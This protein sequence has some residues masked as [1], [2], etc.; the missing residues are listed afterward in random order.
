MDGVGGSCPSPSSPS[1]TSQSSQ[2]TTQT[3]EE[4]WRYNTYIEDNDGFAIRINHLPEDEVSDESGAE[5]VAKNKSTP[6]QTASAAHRSD[7]TRMTKELVMAMKIGE[8]SHTSHATRIAMPHHDKKGVF[9]LTFDGYHSSKAKNGGYGAILRCGNGTPVAAV[10]GGSKYKISPFFHTLEGLQKGLDLVIVRGIKSVYC[11]CN[12]QRVCEILRDCFIFNNE[13]G[14][15]RHPHNLFDFVCPHCLQCK[16]T[17]E[18]P[19]NLVIHTLKD[20]VR[21][22]QQFYRQ[23]QGLVGA[24][25]KEWNKPA[26]YLAKL[27]RGPGEERKLAPEE[28][29]D[30]LLALVNQHGGRNPFIYK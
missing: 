9:L 23:R 21:K 14:C 27:V 16:L 4:N 24:H 26:D 17:A 18:E 6:Q 28:F 22:G 15:R 25:V 2:Q 3:Y 12:S 20:I 29:S 30:D 8:P 19:F 10:A 1:L 5:D 7:V 13:G 11:V